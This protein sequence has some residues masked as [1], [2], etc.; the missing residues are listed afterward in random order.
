MQAPPSAFIAYYRV[1]TDRQGRSG[2]GLEAQRAAVTAHLGPDRKPLQEFTEIE[3]GTRSDRPQLEAA[4]RS[5][6][7]TGAALIV[8]KVDRLARNVR[9]LLSVVEGC[10]DAGVI[11]CDLPQVPPGAVGKFILTQ[12]AAVSEL[13][14]GLISARTKAALA[15]VKARGRTLG[16]Y[17]GG[18]KVDSAAGREA[19]TR[20]SEAFAERL[21]PVILP[22]QKDGMSLRQIGSVLA[23]RGIMTASGGAWSAD[24]VRRVLTRLNAAVSTLT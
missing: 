7:L 9:F 12:M 17:R 23:E 16:G 15:A 8:G 2:L 5:C 18:P 14:A 1:S 6:R 24:A 20:A 22:L 19:R 10:G 13:E 3:S 4:L 11:F 21:R